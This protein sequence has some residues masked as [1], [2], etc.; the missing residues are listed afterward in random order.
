MYK[1][2]YYKKKIKTY[3]ASSA[4]SN[5]SSTA[6]Q[7]RSSRGG[8]SR[9]RT[10]V[11]SQRPTVSTGHQTQSSA[12]IA[13]LILQLERSRSQYWGSTKSSQ[14]S[15]GDSNPTQTESQLH[16]TIPLKTESQLQ[17]TSQMPKIQPIPSP[18]YQQPMHVQPHMPQYGSSATQAPRGSQSAV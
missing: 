11:Q 5:K 17:H 3:G 14:A 12:P 9:T 7:S 6:T 2:P 15:T 1:M 10:K 13:S 8:N 4:T 18:I 16:S